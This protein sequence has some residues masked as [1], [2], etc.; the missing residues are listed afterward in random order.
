MVSKYRKV[1]SPNRIFSAYF[2]LIRITMIENI[3]LGKENEWWESGQCALFVILWS[4]WIYSEI[5]DTRQFGKLFFNRLFDNILLF[6]FNNVRHR[7]FIS[8]SIWGEHMRNI[9]AYLPTPLTSNRH[10]LLHSTILEPTQQYKLLYSSAGCFQTAKI[11][12]A[13]QW[14]SWFDTHNNYHTINIMIENTYE[15]HIDTYDRFRGRRPS[16]AA[17]WI[18]LEYAISI[19]LTCNAAL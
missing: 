5:L 19:S 3:F 12:E 9:A 16:F 2:V 6:R 13:G 15:H 10:Y 4:F 7:N 11:L 14:M 8:W 17:L 1:S 18:Y